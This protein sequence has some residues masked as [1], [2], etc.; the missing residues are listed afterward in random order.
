MAQTKRLI[1]MAEVTLP[2][3]PDGHSDHAQVNV[4]KI[5]SH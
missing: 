4:D 1:H 5:D 2:S 3:F